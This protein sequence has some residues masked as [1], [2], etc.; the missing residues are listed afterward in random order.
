MPIYGRLADFF[1]RKHLMLIGIGLFLVGS[2][3]AGFAWTMP[4]L[5]ASRVAEAGVTVSTSFAPVPA[6]AG[7]A[8]ELKQVIGN[9]LLNALD[10]IAERHREAG[11][12]LTIRID[13]VLR[14][15]RVIVKDDGVGIPPD[16]SKRIFD[17]FYTTK[18]IGSGTGLGLSVCQRII[19]RHGGQIT[20]QSTFGAGASFIVELPV[21]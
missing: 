5:I 13:R 20:V 6:I 10:A 2:V 1:G 12:S 14:G 19:E 8:K 15:V 21:P 17:P 4:V 16:V 7:D 11:G 3:L 18:T 9:L